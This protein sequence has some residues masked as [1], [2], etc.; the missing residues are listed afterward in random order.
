[1]K[2]FPNSNDA[3]SLRTKGWARK[4]SVIPPQ[5]NKGARLN[6]YQAVGTS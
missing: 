4:P 2:E 5:T 1:M 6:N 3:P